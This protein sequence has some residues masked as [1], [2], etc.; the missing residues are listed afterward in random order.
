MEDVGCTLKSP[1]V[2]SFPCLLPGFVCFVSNGR[3]VFRCNCW[4]RLFVHTPPGTWWGNQWCRNILLEVGRSLFCNVWLTVVFQTTFLQ[5]KCILKFW[6]SS[7]TIRLPALIWLSCC[8]A[9]TCWPMFD[10]CRTVSWQLS[11][12]DAAPYKHD[13]LPLN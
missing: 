11:S 12:V 3:I 13:P 8:S 6:L 5:D 9:Q 1:Q 7:S 10:T 2:V 4:I